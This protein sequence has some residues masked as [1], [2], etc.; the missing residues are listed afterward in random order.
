MASQVEIDFSE[1][2]M[3]SGLATSGVIKCLDEVLEWVDEQRLKQNV[4]LEKINFSDLREWI[5]DENKSSIRHASGGFFS[6]IGLS[7]SNNFLDDKDWDQPIIN[8]PEI[9]YLGFITKKINNVLHF[10]VQAKIE[11]GNVGRVQLSPTIQ[12][13]RSNCLQIHA[14]EKPKF[15]EFFEKISSSDVIVDQLQ[16]EQGAR[17]FKKRNRNI[18]IYTTKEVPTAEN[19]IWLTLWQ[20]KQLMRHDNLVNMDSRTVISG[21][22]ST[23]RSETY[24]KYSFGNIFINKSSKKLNDGLQSL[25][26]EIT[27]FKFKYNSTSSIISL[28]SLRKWDFNCCEINHESKSFFKVIAVDVH[29]EGREVSHWTQPMIEP[30]SQG[31]SAFLIKIIEGLAYFLVQLK[32]ECG[33]YDSFEI[34]PTVQSSLSSGSALSKIPYYQYLLDAKSDQILYDTIQSEEGGRFFQEQ[35]RNML[36]LVDPLFSEHLPRGYLWMNLEQLRSFI[37]FNNN[38]NIQARNLLA[39]IHF[40]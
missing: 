2:L 40:G 6:I 38:V 19:F 25:I 3:V 18:V 16:S 26:A 1:E 36:V 31:V 17:F 21:L 8:Q 4:F 39:T 23:I 32:Y 28:N 27:T 24:L 30:V 34:G 29:I 11:P 20:L 37:Q 10:L 7:T 15:L 12:A 9:G 35:N 5:I 13:T 22:L 14:G 33:N